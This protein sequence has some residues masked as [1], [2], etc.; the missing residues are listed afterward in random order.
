MLIGLTFLA[1]TAPALLLA[2]AAVLMAV[3]SVL[4]A[5]P[6]RS[7]TRSLATLGVMGGAALVTALPY[8]LP[9]LRHYQLRIAN[10]AP[11]NAVGIGVLAMGKGMVSWRAALAAWGLVVFLQHCRDPGIR[12]GPEALTLGSLVLACLVWLGLGATYQVLDRL[13]IEWMQVVPEYHFH[14][15]LKSF[16]A[17]FA[18]WGLIALVDA[19]VRRWVARATGPAPRRSPARHT[20][21]P[22]A[23]SSRP[24]PRP[25]STAPTSGFSARSRWP[26]GDRLT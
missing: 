14:M 19:G 25:T 13:G 5:R 20:S 6:A 22:A 9:L 10:A 23:S 7:A 15:Y 2:L 1:R 17:L 24:M 3:G 21:R 16:E 8:L 26:E 11:M 18:G 12:R 4:W